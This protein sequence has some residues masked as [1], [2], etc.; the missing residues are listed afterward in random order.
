MGQDIGNEAPFVSSRMAIEKDWIDYNGHLNMAYYLVLFDRASDEVFACLG[1]GP[2][3][4]ASR[5]LTTYTGKA[6]ITYKRE[7][8]LSMPVICRLQM[9]AHDD[10]RMHTWQ[11]LCHADEG[12]VA[13]TCELISL[14]V[15]MNGPRVAPYPGDIRDRI[16]AMMKAH[17]GLPFPPGAGKGLGISR[18]PV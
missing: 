7:L 11:E 13:A 10:K 12:W 3:Y 6:Q 16:E 5:R 8:H 14:H 4:A 17:A 2:D 1:M 18:K 15:D 9:L